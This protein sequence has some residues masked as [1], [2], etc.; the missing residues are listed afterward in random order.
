M[1]KAKFTTHVIY[2]LCLSAF[3]VESIA[4]GN[5][6]SCLNNFPNGDQLVTAKAARAAL[7]CIITEGVAGPT[8]ATGAT[9]PTGPTGPTGIAGPTG[10]TGPT[11]AAGAAGAV[12]AAGTTA[13][14]ATATLKN[15]DWNTVC[16][17]GT[18]DNSP[19]GCTASVNTPAFKTLDEK[20]HILS[21]LGAVASSDAS[22]YLKRLNPHFA[23]NTGP[24]INKRITDGFNTRCILM[25]EHGDNSLP[26]YAAINNTS[27]QIPVFI[28]NNSN[29]K[30]A[31]SGHD[32]PSRIFYVICASVNAEQ[33]LMPD[34]QIDSIT[35]N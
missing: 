25:D 19:A 35:W 10:A 15:S 29:Y 5:A 11:G 3:A 17:A 2:T 9:G 21:R 14:Q 26:A 20:T 16:T 22:V 12:R 34:A 24:T 23:T 1:N 13:G 18:P 32:Y 7:Q 31:S 30:S 8:G 6:Q 27:A 28:A 4:A 33:I